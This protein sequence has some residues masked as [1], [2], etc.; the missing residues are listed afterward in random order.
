MEAWHRLNVLGFHRPAAALKDELERCRL[1]LRDFSP[2]PDDRQ[3]FASSDRPSDQ[4]QVP[5]EHLP[6]IAL[7]RLVMRLL[8]GAHD[9]GR[10]EKLAWEYL[11]AYRGL[12][13]SIVS[14]SKIGFG[15]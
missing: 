7:V 1:P 4:C 5:R 15:R 11:F 3:G 12:A 9:L 13:C 8:I 2:L 10:A 6:V 14:R